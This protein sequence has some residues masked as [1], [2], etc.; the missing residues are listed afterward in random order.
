MRKIGLLKFFAVD[1][2][3]TFFNHHGI[4]LF[5]HNAFYGVAVVRRIAQH[6]D[7][8]GLWITHMI[9]PAIEDVAFVVTESR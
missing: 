8:R 4:T 6:N 7:L 5:G 9:D 1:E 3:V 2:E